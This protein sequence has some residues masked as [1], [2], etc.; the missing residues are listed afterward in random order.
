MK[1][2]YRLAEQGDLMAIMALIEEARASLARL[3]IDQ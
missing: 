1:H 2:P 3:G